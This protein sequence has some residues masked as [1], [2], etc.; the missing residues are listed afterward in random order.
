MRI[1]PS[2]EN[3][4]IKFYLIE[5]LPYTDYVAFK[6]LVSLSVNLSRCMIEDVN[7]QIAT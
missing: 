6:P 5:A 3:F 2:L 4:L 1:N 7:T